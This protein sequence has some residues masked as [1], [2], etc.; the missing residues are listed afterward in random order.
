MP[1]PTASNAG[2]RSKAT[3]RNIVRMTKL[4]AKPILPNRAIATI[5]AN[6]PAN[7]LPVAFQDCAS[8]F[9]LFREDVKETNIKQDPKNTSPMPS[10]SGKNPD[11]GPTSET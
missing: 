6:Q 5:I 11:P 7:A 10:Q 2:R 4:K 8:L 1:T 3:M 9:A